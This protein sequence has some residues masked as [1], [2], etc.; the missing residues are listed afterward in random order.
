[1]YEYTVNRFT[2]DDQWQLAGTL[3]IDAAVGVIVILEIM[4]SECFS[5][6]SIIKRNIPGLRASVIWLKS[7]YTYR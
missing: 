3:G 6:N 2:R 7:V 1:M 4:F 5:F